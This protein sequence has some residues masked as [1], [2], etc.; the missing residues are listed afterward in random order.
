MILATLILIM[1]IVTFDSVHLDF[2]SGHLDFDS[3]HFAAHL[4]ALELILSALG[5]ILSNIKLI[6]DAFISDS[7]LF[8][9]DSRINPPD[10]DS[11][12]LGQRN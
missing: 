4:A 11:G 7:G 8:G 12:P 1:A 10:L 6:L 5:L 9:F 2:D 3:G